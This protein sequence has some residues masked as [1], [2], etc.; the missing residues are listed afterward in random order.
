VGEPNPWKQDAV[1]DLPTP[2][3]AVTGDDQMVTAGGVGSLVRLRSGTGGGVERTPL[4]AL[5]ALC[6]ADGWLVAG[7]VDGIAR[8]RWNLL[9]TGPPPADPGWERADIRGGRSPVSTI[10]ATRE[11]EALLA[12]TL[13]VGV[14]R[15]TDL[16]RTWAAA[17][18]GLANLEVTGLAVH[19]DG[20]VIAGTASGMFYSRNDGRAWR[21]CQGADERPVEAV[22]CT[23]AGSALAVLEGGATLCS[24]DGGAGWQPGDQAPADATCLL[25][26]PDN[27]VVLGTAQSGIWRSTDA[28]ASWTTVAKDAADSRTVYCLGSNRDRMYAGT[29]YGLVT[30]DDAGAS[31]TAVQV[32]PTH[33]LDRLLALADRLVATGPQAGI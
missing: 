7:G 6:L 21:R 24:A 16:G 8:R 30:S 5:T 27:V 15:S 25:A 20:A 2:I 26:G 14:L 11:G 12:G 19:P 9:E 1:I 18:F 29:S 10:I 32:P 13:T 33:D 3:L 31:W 28:G 22:A 4:T 17:N 23:S